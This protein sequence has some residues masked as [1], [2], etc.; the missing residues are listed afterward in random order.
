[1]EL[2]HLLNKNVLVVG[3]G[4]SGQAAARFCVRS[5]A[6]VR[7]VDT[8]ENPS[9]IDQLPPAAKYVAGGLQDSLL[10][11]TDMVV[12]SPGLSPS[13]EPLKSFVA[14]VNLRGIAC[15]GEIELF[16]QALAY[17][18]TGLSYQPKVV[19]V[20]GTNG[21]TTVTQLTTHLLK[22]TGK[23]VVA[24]GNVSPAALTALCDALD[25]DQLP[26]VWVLELS[27]FQLVGTHSLVAD[28]AC[29]LNVTEDHLDWHVDMDDYRAAKRRIHAHAKA[30]VFNRADAATAPA[31]RAPVKKGEEEL[32]IPH[33]SFAVDEPSE[34]GEFGLVSLN[35]LPWLA[36]AVAAEDEFP[37]SA[38][39]KKKFDKEQR[40]WRMNRLIP[41]DTLKLH[42]SHNYANVLAALALCRVLAIPQA[43]T[44]RAVQT[45]QGEP[46]RCELVRTVDGVDYIDDSKG[47][48][49]GATVAALNGMGRPIVLIAGG[50][51]KGQD[52]SPLQD[53]LSKTTKH[54]LLI[55]KD[56]PT[57]AAIADA[58]CIN[59]EI[60]D[61]L[62]QAVLRAQQVAQTGDI[63]LLSPAC[64]SLDMFKN[65]KHRA[66]VFV[67]AVNQ[68]VIS[69]IDQSTEPAQVSS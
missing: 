50:E 54:I 11:G 59:H 69:H 39:A 41:L 40:A 3:L 20:T 30:I 66:Q 29:I 36:E 23:S 17:L 44:L 57:L 61:R 9:G 63:V 56:A 14:A 2:K 12:Y 48:N 1:M 55:G 68:L 58:A 37:M 8:R 6:T 46:H 18:Q 10:D 24:A 16:A 60:F 26:Q 4:E 19:A 42:G 28:A 38:T 67:S 51:G 35:G 25:T 43:K 27:S 5:G 65:Y 49:V 47:T 52:F 62:E 64:A 22:G 7:V 21:K 53:V 32:V 13:Q 45:Y 34:F 33:Y 15:T 31:T